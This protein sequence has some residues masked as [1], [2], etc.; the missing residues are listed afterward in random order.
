M[1]MIKLNGYKEKKSELRKTGVKKGITLASYRAQ[2]LCALDYLIDEDCGFYVEGYFNEMLS[3]ERKRTE[4]SRKPFLLVLIDISKLGRGD[5]RTDATIRISEALSSSTREI[6]IKGWYTYDSVIGIIFTEIDGLEKDVMRDKIAGNL[7]HVLGVDKLK[8]IAISCHIFPE[9]ADLEKSKETEADSN[10]YPDLTQSNTSRKVSLF[11]KRVIDIMGSIFGISLFFPFFLI[12]PLAIRITSKGPVL[13]RQERVGR[14]GKTFT[15]LK[16]R[17]MF[18]D[19][20]DRIHK[21]YIKELIKNRKS[22]ETEKKKG[23]KQLVYKIN[24][25]PRVTPIG[26]FLRKSSLDELPQFFNVLKG[27]MSLVGPRPPIPYELENYEI[28][29]RRRIREVKPGITGLWQVYG[30]SRTTF[31]EMVRMDVQYIREWSLFL[32]IKILIRTPLAVLTGRGA[33]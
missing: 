28:W 25:D 7:A 30:R 3:I 22:I 10:L 14:F 21:E 1:N 31:D 15:F 6:D 27:D 24:N 17:T 32:D 18:I 5:G 13:F 29:H 9:T 20:D 19:C 33:C 11:V 26:R 23:E 4:R 16:F 12:I 8:N 2:Q